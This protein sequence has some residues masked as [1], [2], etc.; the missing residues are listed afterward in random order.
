MWLQNVNWCVYM[1]KNAALSVAVESSTRYAVKIHRKKTKPAQISWPLYIFPHLFVAMLDLSCHERHVFTLY[2]GILNPSSKFRVDHRLC[3]SLGGGGEVVRRTGQNDH[4]EVE[5][6]SSSCVPL[7]WALS[8]S[9]QYCTV[10]SA[11]SRWTC[12]MLEVPVTAVG[13]KWLHLTSGDLCDPNTPVALVRMVPVTTL[14]KWIFL[15]F[16]Q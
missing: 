7:C 8:P 9:L 10:N 3:C 5:L 4:K 14:S 13:V 1:P 16:M 15:F 6:L 12:V 2:I 11:A